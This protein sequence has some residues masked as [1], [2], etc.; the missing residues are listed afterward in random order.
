MIELSATT[1]REARGARWTNRSIRSAFVK[2][3]EGEIRKEPL[4]G[5]CCLPKEQPAEK[6]EMERTKSYAEIS[7][8]QR[9][10]NW[11]LG[12]SVR[13]GT[14]R[15]FNSDKFSRGYYSAVKF[16]FAGIYRRHC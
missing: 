6:K 7:V 10:R 3:G 1:K 5:K 14:A 11:R 12:R 9:A 13:R 16:Y 15:E 4:R 8:N 2:E